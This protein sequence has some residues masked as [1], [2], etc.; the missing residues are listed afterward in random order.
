MLQKNT[1]VPHCGIKT[2]INHNFP[3]DFAARNAHIASEP[4]SWQ[5]DLK[6]SKSRKVVVNNFSAA[7]G[8]SA[9]LIEDAPRRSIDPKN[10]TD[11]RSH[12]LVAISAKNAVSVQNNLRALLDHLGRTQVS[13]PSLSYTTSARRTHHP[14]RV[15][16]TGATVQ[17]VKKQ[18][19]N[20]LDKNAGANRPKGSP[21]ILFAFTGQGAHYPGEKYLHTLNIVTL[22]QILID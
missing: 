4:T 2:K 3:T 10:T 12:H 9:L 16:V 17:D 19:Q 7:G 6:S 14:H 1:I 8:N 11:P 5:M 15:M 21:N 18:L 13:L 22:A 20:E